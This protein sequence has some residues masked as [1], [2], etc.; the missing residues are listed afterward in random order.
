[1]KLKMEIISPSNRIAKLKIR[2]KIF[3][4]YDSKNELDL[5]NLSIDPIIL[6]DNFY[7]EITYSI[8]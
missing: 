1:M 8:R 5:Y 3:R 6:T 4:Y 2:S 7:K